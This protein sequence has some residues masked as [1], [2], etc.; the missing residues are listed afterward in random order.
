EAGQAVGEDLWQHGD[1]AV[2]KIDA[3]PAVSGSAVESRSGPHE[4]TDIGDVDGQAPVAV[5]FARQRDRIVEV[6]RGRWIDRDRRGLAEVLARSDASLV[7]PPCLLAGLLE[8]R[9]LEAVWDVECAND[10]DRVDP[11]LAS[12]TED[13]GDNPFPFEVRGRISDDLDRDLVAGLDS[14][15]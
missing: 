2:G 7:E 10:R 13:L 4:M 15:G 1:N 12:L 6:A 3:R 14:A 11:R 5:L 8:N 9:L